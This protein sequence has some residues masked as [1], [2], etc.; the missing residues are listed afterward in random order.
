MEK[1]HTL[2]GIVCTI[3]GSA[4]WGFSGTCSQYLFTYKDADSGWLTMV[5]MISA[6]I[7]LIL[8]GIPKYKNQFYG[9]IKNKSDLKALLLF[10]A[11]GLLTCQYAYLTAVANSNAGTATVLQYLEPVIVMLF[12]CLR[13]GRRPS[14]KETV[15][16]CLALFGVFLIATGGDVT[17]LA[18][19]GKGL[20]WGIAAAVAASACAIMPVNI[21]NKWG[22]T[23]VTGY[24]ML[25]G[26][27]FL[28]ILTG[29]HTSAPTLDIE[30]LAC[31]T[32]T[33]VLGTAVAFTLFLRGISDIGPVKGAIIGSVEPV[34]AAFFS[35]ALLGTPF[36]L[37]DAA[38][39]ICILSAVPLLTYKIKN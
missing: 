23:V 2:R 30:V 20:F 9:I 36:T 33:V 37:I 24:A 22:S 11:A 1:V 27:I 13:T 8:F 35:F 6:G 17:S 19:S 29:W 31:T 12:V 16:V 7:I 4:C 32:V 38:A 18:I 10:S 21:I 28:F 34:S 5:R 3:A 15:S 39:F 26:G 25:F 14:L